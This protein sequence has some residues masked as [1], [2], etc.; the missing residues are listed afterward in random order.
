MSPSESQPT[1]TGP[2]VGA[3]PSTVLTIEDINRI[4]A[5]AKSAGG[6][7]VSIG[8]QIFG[9][10]GDNVSASG[11]IV[12]Q[13]LSDSNLSVQGPLAVLLTAAQAITKVGTKVQ[14]A[15][16]NE[17]TTQISGTHIRFK[18]AVSFDVGGDGGLVTFSNIVG[19]A[20]HKLFWIDVTEIQLRQNQGQRVLHVVTSEGSRDF[21]L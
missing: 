10:L 2:A 17:I 4:I 19:V 16:L 6:D 14:I 21:A 18:E 8:M 12:A 9:M 3:S 20:A 7:E 11:Q 13:V 1:G 15:N 5:Q